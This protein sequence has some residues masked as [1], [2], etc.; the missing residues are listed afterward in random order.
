M[1]L[2]LLCFIAILP[3]GFLFAS[4]SSGSES[5]NSVSPSAVVRELN[6]ARENPDAYAAGLEELR[7]SFQGKMLVVSGHRICTREGVKA[8]DEAIRFLHSA[9]PLKPL[10]L[11]PGLSRSAAD[12]CADLS[13]GHLGHRGSDGSNPGVRMNRYGTWSSL[14][15]ENLSFGKRTARDI[16]FQLI[17]DDGLSSRKH[18]KNIFNPRFNFAGAAYGTHASYGSVCSIDLAAGYTENGSTLVARNY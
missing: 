4:D 16:V 12:H 1:R 13:G 15:G 17:I 11:S 6:R 10:V 14:W 8:V 9:K 2:S 5:G 18:R 7:S 3:S